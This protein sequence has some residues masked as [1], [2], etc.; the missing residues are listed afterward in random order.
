M[1]SPGPQINLTALAGVANAAFNKVF[2]PPYDPFKDDLSFLIATYITE[3]V[4]VA[5]YL[6]LSPQTRTL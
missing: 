3:D 1:L 2:D 6:V 5:A 4:G